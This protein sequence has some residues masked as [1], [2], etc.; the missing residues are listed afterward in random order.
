M[1]DLRTLI[2]AAGKGTRMKSEV[3]K[4]LHTVCGDPIINYVLKVAK[5]VGSLKT[6]VVLGHKREMIKQ[7][8]PNDLVFVDQIKQTGT[9][10]A[11]QCAEDHLKGYSG[12]ILILCG[13][14]PLLNKKVIKGLVQKHK[15]KKA[16]CTFLTSVVHNP[17]G[18]GRVIRD[19]S[20]KAAAIR[21][22]KD[23]SDRERSI[24]EINVGVYCFQSKVLFQLLKEI[25]QNKKKKEFYLTDIIALLY[26]ANEKVE[27]VEANDPIEG[28]GVNTLEDLA[29]AE[30]VVQKNI[31]REF[32][33]QGVRI[34][35]P[36]TT[37]IDASVKIGTDT[38]I[39]PF[40]FIERGVCIGKRCVI[41]PFAR[42]RYDSK[43]GNDVEIG[44][45]T[46]VVRTKIDDGC[47]M[48]HL[49][50][51]GD[52]LVGSNV[53]IGA[54]TVVAN[55]DGVNKHTTRIARNAFIGCDSVLISPV[56]V[57]E[58]AIVGAG[59][60]VTKGTVIPAGGVVAGV[61]AKIISKRGMK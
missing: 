32:M 20:G 37:Y 6:Y 22:D 26:E 52:S 15:K 29:V 11:V 5:F 33:L 7:A 4:V 21:E 40:S 8:L 28:L 57:G 9:A 49:S 43:I 61:P 10:S 59:S 2:L 14:T 19:L 25:K 23:A 45:F 46:E 53:N 38:V 17:Q 60:V 1:Q 16:V 18:Y 12:D 27:T 30:S 31:L 58:K 55:F 56:Q 51:L 47:F 42:L 13:D 24:A 54:G 39:K 35:D 36:N 41:G 48:K 34:V 50:Y 44:N 3:P